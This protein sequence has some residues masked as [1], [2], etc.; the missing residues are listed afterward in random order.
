MTVEAEN[1]APNS[2]PNLDTEPK[3]NTPEPSDSKPSSQETSDSDLSR[4][5]TDSSIETDAEN[6]QQFVVRNYRV[7]ECMSNREDW[8]SKSKN[9]WKEVPSTVDG[10]LGGYGS[11]THSDLCSSAM[12]LAKLYTGLN[13]ERA[14]DCGAGIGRVT[15][16][17]LLNIFDKVEMIDTCQEHL[18]S[19]REYLGED[20]FARVPAQ[21]CCGLEDFH[22]E[23]NTYDLVWVQ[24]VIIYLSD[25]DFI[26]LL[27]RF[28][29]SLKKDGYIVVKDNVTKNGCELD[30]NDSSVTRSDYQLKQIFKRAGLE[31]VV[32]S[33]QKNFPR[34]LF[35]VK[36]YAMR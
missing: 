1:V 13:T 10:M 19:A 32:D 24:W 30:D 7:Q 16:G 5:H 14:L 31:I 12:F 22:P 6:S 26:E 29:K 2:S 9:Y 17:L 27:A 34:E 25:Y 4:E 8:Y 28:K 11:L 3:L 20:M 23:P 36:Y 21:H 15:K 18:D 33:F 35:K